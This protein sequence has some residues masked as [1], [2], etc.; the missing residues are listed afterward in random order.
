MRNIRKEFVEL[1]HEADLKILP[2][3]AHPGKDLKKW[4]ECGVDGIFTN[5]AQEFVDLVK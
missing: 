5:N 4:I 3:V 2:F 1:A